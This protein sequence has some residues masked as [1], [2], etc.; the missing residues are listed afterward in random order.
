LTIFQGSRSDITV[1]L[2]KHSWGQ[3]SVIARIKGAGPNADE[4][5]IIGA[6][7]DSTNGGGSKRSPGADDDASGTST[8]L[9]VT[10]QVIKN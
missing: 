1:S 7:E 3:P 5:V 9:E 2:F 4:V 6:H 8:V 10:V